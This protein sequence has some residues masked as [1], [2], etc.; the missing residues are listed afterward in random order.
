[1]PKRGGAIVRELMLSQEL[2]E[3]PVRKTGKPIEELQEE[4]GLE[5]VARL[6]ANENPLG[7]SPLA[8]E[9]VR[10]AVG[11]VHR[12]PGTCEDALRSKIANLMGPGF[13]QDHVLIANGS[14]DVLRVLC[15]AFLHG[16][17]QSIICPATFPLYELY[18]KMF[19]GDPVLIE[20][21]DYAYDLPA[22]SVR[23]GDRTRLVFVCNPN[24]PTGT[25]LTQGQVDEFMEQVPERVVVVFDE[26]YCDYV[27]EEDY[28]DVTQYI[29]EGRNVIIARTFSKIYG[30]AGLRVGYAIAKKD[31]IE[32]LLRALS[33]YHSGALSLIGAT[34]ALGDEEH[35]RRS[36]EHNAGQ[37]RYLY[38]ELDRLDVH[39]IATQCNFILLVDLG[40]DVPAL[41]QA[42][43]S[44]GVVVQQTQAFG[45]PDALR[46]T[47]GTG[48]ENERLIEALEQ[49]LLEVAED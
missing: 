34:A 25:V 26:A 7:P 24:N 15:Q 23:I 20:P 19:G 48:E 31:L 49:V 27:E 17:G 29:R 4:F 32:Y 6:F 40:Q 36:R 2:S 37:K 12:Y 14:C 35:I 46:I 39:Y 38:Q 10:D 22:M 21:K 5:E 41:W 9:A 42:L 43:V 45:V 3:L 47:I 16:G 18:T 33:P 44:R 30:L 28:A 13:D 1:M 8:V 11:Q